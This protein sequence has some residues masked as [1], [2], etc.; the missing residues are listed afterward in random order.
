PSVW[1][2]GTGSSVAP[3]RC[4]TIPRAS[5]APSPATADIASLREDGQR[6]HR[7]LA[8]GCRGSR[9]C[10]SRCEQLVQT[11]NNVTR[12]KIGLF[13]WLC[14]SAD[15]DEDADTLAGAAAGAGNDDVGVPIAGDVLDQRGDRVAD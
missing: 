1:S 15:V 9:Q 6:D 12:A 11:S 5:D 14:S 10:R 7:R 3:V 13:I 8:A 2:T 4:T